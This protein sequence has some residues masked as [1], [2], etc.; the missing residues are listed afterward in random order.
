MAD[1]ESRVTISV[2]K[3]MQLWPLLIYYYQW[4]P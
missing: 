2:L 3:L 1:S 4:L